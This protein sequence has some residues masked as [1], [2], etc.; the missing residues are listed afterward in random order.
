M[1]KN[2][3]SFH[4]IH[5]MKCTSQLLEHLNVVDHFFFLDRKSLVCT[6]QHPMKL[7]IIF[8]LWLWFW[9][10]LLKVC[11]MPFHF[12]SFC[13]GIKTVET[14]LITIRKSLPLAACCWSNCSDTSMYA[15]S[16]SSLS[17]HRTQWQQC[18]WYLIAFCHLLHDIVSSDKLHYDF[19]NL[20]FFVRSASNSCLLHS[21]VV[22]LADCCRVDHW[23]LLPSFKCFTQCCMHVAPVHATSVDLRKQVAAMKKEVTCSSETFVDFQWITWLY[24]PGNI[25]L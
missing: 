20:W 6:P 21:M 16:C 13:F 15:L 11:M 8:H 2:D 24:I 7:P 9:P 4:W 14:R 18:L 25:T 3:V 17:D 23:C 10:S 19:P 12:L 5:V 22:V 1:L